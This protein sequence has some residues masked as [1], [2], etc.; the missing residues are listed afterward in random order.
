[1]MMMW[2]TVLYDATNAI[3][4]LKNLLLPLIRLSRESL[5]LAVLVLL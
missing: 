1:M 2:A 3:K 4:Q 5:A